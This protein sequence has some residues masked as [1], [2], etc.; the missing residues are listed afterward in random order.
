MTSARANTPGDRGPEPT[1]DAIERLLCL[2]NEGK[3]LVSPEQA[4]VLL[5]I[6]RTKVFELIATGAIRS[7]IVGR[8]RKISLIELRE[9]V[10]TL[11]EEQ[12]GGRAEPAIRRTGDAR[13]DGQ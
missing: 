11:Y 9:F 10:R 5:D 3:L 13:K 7:V 2:S 8:M 6:G 4:A 12:S 1:L